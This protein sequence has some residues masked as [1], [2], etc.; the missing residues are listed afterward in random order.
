MSTKSH[1]H[2]VPT[3]ES[4]LSLLDQASLK[5]T[6]ARKALLEILVSQHGPF[7]V[8]ELRHAVKNQSLDLVTVYRCLTAFE[9]IGLVRRCDFGDGTARY[10]LQTKTEYHHHH[11][12]CKICRKSENIDDCEVDRLEKLVQKKGYSKITHNL[13]FFGVCKECGT[14]SAASNT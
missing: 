12:I 11:V 2:E 7:S 3:L 1:T 9:E 8:E 5:K 14:P 13:E 6:P 10:E 4:V